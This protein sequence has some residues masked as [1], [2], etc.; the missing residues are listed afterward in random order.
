MRCERF[1][2]SFCM[3]F[4]KLI[5]E[6][7]FRHENSVTISTSSSWCSPLGRVWD[8]IIVWRGGLSIVSSGRIGWGFLAKFRKQYWKK[9]CIIQLANQISGIGKRTYL[10]SGES[11][12]ET[13]EVLTS[14]SPNIF[15]ISS[16]QFVSRRSCPRWWNFITSA[17]RVRPRIIVRSRFIHTRDFKP[18]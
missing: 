14:C 13:T 5:V 9:L 18:F 11:A 4:A 17:G 6:K 2:D 8:L 12:L 16:R 1:L 3:I 7:K 10:F 15:M